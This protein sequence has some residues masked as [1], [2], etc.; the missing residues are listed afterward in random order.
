[1]GQG[2]GHTPST[3]AP[4][5]PQPED[6]F[7]PIAN[8]ILW[9]LSVYGAKIP[10][11]SSSWPV[12]MHVF[13]NTYGQYDPSRRK[14]RCRFRNKIDLVTTRSDVALEL[15]LEPRSVNRAIAALE[16]NGVL[17]VEVL[18]S[19]Q[20]KEILLIRFNKNY[21]EWKGFQKSLRWSGTKR[22]HRHAI[23]PGVADDTDDSVGP[24]GLTAQSVGPNGLSGSFGQ[25]GNST[26]N[27]GEENGVDRNFNWDQTVPPVGPNGPTESGLG[28]ENSGVP[29]FTRQ[30]DQTN[31]DNR[32][33][34]SFREQWDSTI[35]VANE[36]GYPS[37]KELENQWFEN[38][39]TG[40]KACQTFVARDQPA[41]RFALKQF[42]S[43]RN[44]LREAN[45]LQFVP[46]NIVSVM[47][48][49]SAF[50]D[51]YVPDSDQEWL[52][53]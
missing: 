9:A 15:H 41:I 3:D 48:K 49:L 36:V 19:S 22:S 14:R 34:R 27:D 20:R 30:E 35:Q 44:E 16:N 8:E 42:V 47:S 13:E 32:E 28:Q 23:E 11:P 50:A 17:L 12:L 6:G 26:N 25:S 24:N 53:G 38:A 5:T 45:Q 4:S 37:F 1:M 46:T 40:W 7:A 2:S 21:R 52:N 51:A 43:M 29:G 10:R 31:T 33:I 18:K 39:G